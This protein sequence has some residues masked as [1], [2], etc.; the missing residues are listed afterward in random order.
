ME[1]NTNIILF[2]NGPYGG[3]TTEMAIGTQHNVNQ[4]SMK[5]VCDEVTT[6]TNQKTNVC[7][8][9]RHST[10]ETAAPGRERTVS[11]RISNGSLCN[12]PDGLPYV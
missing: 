10:K 11:E 9:G 2:K 3:F 7:R 4:K 12:N 6:A 8:V 1:P 5:D